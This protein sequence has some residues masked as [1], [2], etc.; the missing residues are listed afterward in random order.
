MVKVVKFISLRIDEGGGTM[1][2]PAGD[3]A[4]FEPTGRV[5][6]AH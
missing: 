1:A 2:H 4:H 6:G 5:S 3:R